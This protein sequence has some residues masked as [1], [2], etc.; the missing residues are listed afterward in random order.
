MKKLYFTLLL[1]AFLLTS[2]APRAL[3]PP[4]ET[5]SFVVSMDHPENRLCHVEFH[6]EGLA[7]GRHDFIMPAWMPGDYRMQNYARSVTNFTAADAAGRT[8]TWVK[9]DTNTWRVQSDGVSTLTVS[10]DIIPGQA[11]AQTTLSQSSGFIAPAG[12]YMYLDG[13]ILHPVTVT[14]KPKEGWMNIATGLDPVP[15]RSNTFSAPD[16]D[17]LYDCPT[18]LGNLEVIPFEVEG[19][20]HTVKP[21]SHGGYEEQAVKVK[22]HHEFDG[23]NLGQFDHEK[24]VSDL[25]RMVESATALMGDIGYEHYTFIVAGRNAGIEHL[26]ET[27]LP[28]NGSDVSNSIRNK[29]WLSF[30]AH[31]Y[32]HN[33]NVKRIRPIVLGPF[34]YEH[35]NRTH[36]LWVSEGFTDYYAWRVL[37]RAGLMDVEDVL[38]GTGGARGF[39]GLAGAIASYENAP[40]HLYQ[41]AAEASWTTWDQRFGG[42]NRGGPRL[43]I[44]YYDKGNIIGTLL[45]LK[46]RHE[47]QNRKSLD[48]VMRGIYQ[49]YYQEKKR[50]FT[51]QEF[52]QM[53][54]RMAG[55]KLDEAFDYVYTTKPLDYPKYFDYA[56]LNIEMPKE[57]PGAS[58]CG[59]VRDNEGKLILTAVE[60]VSGT[61]QAGLR[62]Q[63][64]IVTANGAT[65][66]A[67]AFSQLLDSKK[68]GEQIEIVYNR[69]GATN[70]VK[71][72]LGRKL[73]RGKFTITPQAH[74]NALQAAILKDWLRGP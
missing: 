25:K 49:E 26:D 35:E 65:L 9:A 45:D 16:F 30:V 13:Q 71:V 27:T 37:R 15:G 7:G 32:F 70:R 4:R 17:I 63:D 54:E 29:H 39:P 33:F 20:H 6:C 21:T 50:G 8:L 10:Y 73:D 24:F 28:F 74:P 56:G 11:A 47:S 41:S 43:T 34:D 42:P 55:A 5:L 36:M 57:L 2:C 18:L 12:T 69:A 46:I 44:S 31:E 67:A 66:D 38:N 22:I 58:F 60:P 23:P 48:D 59:L 64:Q 40:G 1:P 61:A 62:A 19:V 52:R 53:C 68:P 72:T 3:P 51:D 14:I